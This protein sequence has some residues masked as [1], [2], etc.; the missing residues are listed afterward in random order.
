MT[1]SQAEAWGEDTERSRAWLTGDEEWS[2][3]TLS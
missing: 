2:K 1:E 3:G